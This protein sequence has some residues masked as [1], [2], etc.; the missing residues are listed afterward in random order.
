MIRHSWASRRELC[1]LP[2]WGLVGAWSFSCLLSVNPFPFNSN[3]CFLSYA[4]KCATS[5]RLQTAQTNRFSEN[6]HAL[7]PCT[8]VR[9]LRESLIVRGFEEHSVSWAPHLRDFR[10]NLSGACWS[11]S[12]STLSILV[13]DWVTGRWWWWWEG[14]QPIPQLNVDNNFTGRLSHAGRGRSINDPRRP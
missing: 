3:Y 2:H 5:T 8:S 4:H 11:I 1:K 6:N 13:Q 7:S 10:S 14:G 9:L 12:L